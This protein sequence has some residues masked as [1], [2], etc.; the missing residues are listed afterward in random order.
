M[1]R[2]RNDTP[3][4]NIDTPFQQGRRLWGDIL[5][6]S[7]KEVQ[8]W[9]WVSAVA[10][11]VSVAS[12]G[13]LVYVAQDVRTVP[14]IVEVSTEGQVRSVGKLLRPD[15]VPPENV[16]LVVLREWIERTRNIPKDPVAFSRG[17]EK[18]WAY[19]SP[20]AQQALNRY[21]DATHLRE[22]AGVI[23]SATAREVVAVDIQS[24]LPVMGSE[25]T[26]QIRWTETT[27]DFQ[28]NLVKSTVPWTAVVYLIHRPPKPDASVDVKLQENPLGLYVDDFTW[29]ADR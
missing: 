25:N 19:A 5:G 21:V 4:L 3:N 29:K 6:A 2:S 23:L 11:G 16:R 18:V 24:I 20:T 12:L 1:V 28:H 15:Y 10:V 26:Y 17:W 13:A 14:F 7:V 27:T 9:R 22:R 8:A